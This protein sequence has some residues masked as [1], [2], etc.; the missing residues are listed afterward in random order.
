M[1]TR[2]KF[3]SLPRDTR[4][5]KAA[6]LLRQ[7]AR[8]PETPR[9]MR[10]L[11]EVLRADNLPPES[12]K[13]LDTVLADL[14][15]QAAPGAKALAWNMNALMHTLMKDLGIETADWDLP[16]AEAAKTGENSGGEQPSPAL[17]PRLY[18]DGIRSP[19]N[20]G[21]VFRTAECFGAREI[22][23]EPGSASPLHPRAQRSAMGCIDRV[24]WRFAD[25]SEIEK[26]TGL[27]ALELGGTPLDDFVFPGEGLCILGSEELGVRPCL[28]EAAR[29]SAGI[30]SI[31]LAGKKASLNVSVAFG[32]LM[33][34]WRKAFPV[35]GADLSG[36]SW[37]V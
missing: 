6:R 33:H 36:T 34:A 32:I 15:E 22:L 10:E 29:K 37:Q 16:P 9:L 28:L 17:L 5:R 23:I 30:V 11:L 35:I 19:F 2:R 21:S 12:E 18:I 24:P 26:E 25:Y 13:I 4:L 3:L 27:F 8:A 14:T 20:M 31:P 1:I 7:W